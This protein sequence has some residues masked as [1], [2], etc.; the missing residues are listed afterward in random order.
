MFQHMGNSTEQTTWFLKHT[1]K[2][3]GLGEEKPQREEFTD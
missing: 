3:W 2:G 1:A